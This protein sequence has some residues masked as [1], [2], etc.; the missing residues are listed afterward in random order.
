MLFQWIEVCIHVAFELSLEPLCAVR[1]SP[2]V[3][4]AVGV[5]PII[6]ITTCFISG[7]LCLHTVYLRDVLVD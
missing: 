3:V 4:C 7:R 1:Q 6:F 2:V 5:P